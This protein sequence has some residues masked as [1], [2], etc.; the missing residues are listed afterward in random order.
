MKRRDHAE[1]LLVALLPAED[2]ET[3]NPK[4]AQKL[5]ALLLDLL[6]VEGGWGRHDAQYTLFSLPWHLRSAILQPLLDATGVACYT[7]S[8]FFPPLP[9]LRT[10]PLAIFALL[11]LGIGTPASA[12]TSDGPDT[13]HALQRI[14]IPFPAGET[15]LTRGM[16]TALVVSRLYD[17]TTIDRCYWDIGF[18]LPPRFSLV[19]R[20]VPIDHPHAK[21]LCVAM[22]DG[23]I[24]GFGDGTFRPD[25]PIT[26]A[27]AA[28]ILA[29]SHGLTPYADAETHAVW[30]TPYV[31]AL[32]ARQ[33]PIADDATLMRPIRAAQ[34]ADMLLHLAEPPSP[35]GSASD[36]SPE[37]AV[38]PTDATDAV[39]QR[40]QENAIEEGEERAATDGAP[41]DSLADA[42][43]T[44]VQ[45]DAEEDDESRDP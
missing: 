9:M 31:Q 15:E 19:F 28:K 36:A 35:S 2:D 22:R 20:D 25:L 4:L 32:R 27:E 30:H 12:Q 1:L 40:E 7:P 44:A 5:L 45:P 33:V 39:D 34:L 10:V 3:G 43:A 37:E 8:L 26:Q 41:S 13:T 38:E 18:P 29:R 17:P 24:R 21:H 6:V 14:V 16:F 42:D 11:L 23:L